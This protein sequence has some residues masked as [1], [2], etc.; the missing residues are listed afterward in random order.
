MAFAGGLGARIFLDQVPHHGDS[1]EFNPATAPGRLNALL[2]FSES[3]TRFLCEVPPDSVGLFESIL[4][5]VPHSAI[6]EVLAEP[7]LQFV[8]VDAGNPFHVIDAS[9]AALKEAWQKPLRW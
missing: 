4:G 3:N 1:V 6:G 5:D 7:K 8:N 2:L 9:L